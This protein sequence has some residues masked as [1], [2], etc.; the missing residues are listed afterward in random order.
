MRQFGGARN[1]GR[2]TSLPA[3]VL[4][5]TALGLGA[6]FMIL[7]LVWMLTTSFKP[8]VEIPLWPPRLL[9]QAPTLANYTGVFAAAPFGRF[10]LNSAGLSLAATLSVI[11]TSLIAGGI[12]A[13][14]TFVGRPFIFMLIIATAIVPF[15]TYMIPLYIQLIPLGWINTYQGI[16]LPFLVMSF[17]IFLLRQH[18]SS[19]VSTEPRS[20]GFCFA[21]SRRCLGRR[22][23]SLEFSRLFTCGP[24]SF[25]RFLSRTISAYLTWRS[26]SRYFNF[27]SRPTMGNSWPDR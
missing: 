7:P 17:G 4:Q 18:V 3:M 13:K 5:H 24:R 6:V 10:F 12:F 25:G 23:A 20:G 8:P 11:V 15:E 26:A 21:S 2:A 19:A 9:P 14:Y 16:V 22:S 27:G 1:R